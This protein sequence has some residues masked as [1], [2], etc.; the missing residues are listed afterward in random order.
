MQEV[1]YKQGQITA[2][3]V[4]AGVPINDYHTNTLL[5]GTKTVSKSSL[6]PIYR[7]H[8]GSPKEFWG[9]WIH[10]P[11]S[12]KKDST[13]P[14]EFGKAAHALLLG[15]VTGEEF[16][17]NF[18]LRPECWTDYRKKDAKEWRDAVLKEGRSPITPEDM[19]IIIIMSKE[20]AQN[21]DV[22]QLGSL[23]GRTERTMYAVH[24]ET[25][26]GVCSRPDVLVTP[27]LTNDLKTTA[28]LEEAFLRRQIFDTGIYLQ[29]GQFKLLCELLGIDFVGFVCTFVLK[30]EIPD[31]VVVEIEPEHIELGYQATIEGL[32]M[33]RSGLDT[34]VWPGVE[35]F[36]AG[37]S[38]ARL[39]D[40]SAARVADEIKASRA[41]RM[42][43]E[44]KIAA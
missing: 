19:D 38:H 39:N 26:I 24:Q 2:P 31:S 8:G 5:F 18:A 9:R 32:H 4:Y 1:Q 14:L 21:P 20:L 22:A 12:K 3:G 13:A 41:M 10:N 7:P 35:P 29:A 43:D 16:T 25:G 28:S 44:L 15:D 6:K 17:Q 34:G 27:G 37:S 23:D 42:G 30:S 11:Q 40:W 36:N 33:V